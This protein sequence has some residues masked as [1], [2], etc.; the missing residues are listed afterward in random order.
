MLPTERLPITIDGTTEPLLLHW[1][2]GHEE[3]GRLFAALSERGG[4]LMPR[5]NYGFSREFAWVNDRFGVSWQL[6]LT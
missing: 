6:N 4:V 3:L 2:T 5:G 1:M